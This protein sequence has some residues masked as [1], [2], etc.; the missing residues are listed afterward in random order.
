VK[1]TVRP[2]GSAPRRSI[3]HSAGAVRHVPAE[4]YVPHT[5]SKPPT[6]SIAPPRAAANVGGCVVPGSVES[7]EPVCD[8]IHRGVAAGDEGERRVIGG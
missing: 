1:S 2:H 7:V 5:Y 8:V 4:V 3:K 6:P